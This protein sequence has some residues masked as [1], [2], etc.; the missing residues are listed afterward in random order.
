MLR[1][2]KTG[3]NRVPNSVPP[4]GMRPDSKSRY[5]RPFPDRDSLSEEY[6]FRKMHQQ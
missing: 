1:N 3:E 5:G 4:A 2:S 6:E